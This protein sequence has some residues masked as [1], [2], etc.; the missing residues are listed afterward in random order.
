MSTSQVYD[1]LY[2][3]Y[4]CNPLTFNLIETPFSAFANRAD[5]DQTRAA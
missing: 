2:V 1:P 4:V 5:P 3:S